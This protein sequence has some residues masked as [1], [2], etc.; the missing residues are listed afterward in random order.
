[1]R[2]WV[3]DERQAVALLRPP[4]VVAVPLALHR[5]HD[6]VKADGSDWKEEV[7]EFRAL[8]VPVVDV[9]LPAALHPVLR[10]PL[11]AVDVIPWRSFVQ[12]VPHLQRP[13]ETVD[14]VRGT[15]TAH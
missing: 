2:N 10:L 5:P 3:V 8:L 4:N 9:L 15:L 7:D 6:P 13:K 12:L 1:M 14:C 11:L